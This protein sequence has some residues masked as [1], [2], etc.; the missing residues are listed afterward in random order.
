MKKCIFFSGN[1]SHFLLKISFSLKPT[2]IATQLAHQLP[3]ASSRQIFYKHGETV[4]ARDSPGRVFGNY[5]RKDCRLNP[6][7]CAH[8]HQDALG[9]SSLLDRLTPI[10]SCFALKLCSCSSAGPAASRTES[11]RQPQTAR[12]CPRPWDLTVTGTTASS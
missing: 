2:V 10:L 3:S 1:F 7:P 9:N 6:S 11:P 4:L 12:Q 8:M 5:S